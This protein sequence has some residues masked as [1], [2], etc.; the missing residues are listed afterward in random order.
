MT[1][2]TI[3]QRLVQLTKDGEGLVKMRKEMPF[4]LRFNPIQDAIQAAKTGAVFMTALNLRVAGDLLS[5]VFKGRILATATRVSAV[6]EERYQ[7]AV[8]K[9]KTERAKLVY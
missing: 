6:H 2:A 7:E 8:R 5:P 4:N 3:E 9:Q 1:R